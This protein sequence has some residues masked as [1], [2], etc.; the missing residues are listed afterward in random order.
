MDLSAM[1]GMRA[2]GNGYV[3]KYTMKWVG[4]SRMIQMR[5]TYHFK[6]DD[7]KCTKPQATSASWHAWVNIAAKEEK[8]DDPATTI[9]GVPSPAAPAAVGGS[10]TSGSCPVSIQ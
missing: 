4:H 10:G 5:L 6:S 7:F 2:L 3:L 8:E 1:V 9:T